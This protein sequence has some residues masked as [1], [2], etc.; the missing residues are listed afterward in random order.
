MEIA[1]VSIIAIIAI[2]VSYS[3]YLK[4]Q[5]ITAEKDKVVKEKQELQAQKTED[6]TQNRLMKQELEVQ[7]R[8]I[9]QRINSERVQLDQLQSQHKQQVETLE[10]NYNL[11]QRQLDDEFNRSKS[12]LILE[13]QEQMNVLY[14]EI[15]EVQTE[16]NKMR[17]TKAAV[18]EA[19][20]KEEAIKKQKDLYRIDIPEQDLRDMEIL[21]S[22]ENRLSAPRVLRML[23]W[24][25]YVQ[26]I[27]KTKFPIIFNGKKTSGIYKITNLKNEKCYIGQAVDLYNR[28]CQHLKCG[29]GIDTPQGNKLYSAMRKDGIQNFTFEL[30]EECVPEDLDEKER[31]YIG[32]YNSVDYGYNGNAGNKKKEK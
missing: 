12:K 16:L 13:C 3:Y 29:L 5:E 15:N 32:V 11:K 25:T 26:P 20:Q 14:G 19:F 6:L 4:V 9:Q 31:F 27:A 1:F 2:I 30:L 7:S 28:A 10:Q 22:I 23:I 8:E 17:A 21:Q 24:Q 18:I